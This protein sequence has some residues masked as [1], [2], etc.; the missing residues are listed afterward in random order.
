[1]TPKPKYWLLALR[2]KTLTLSVIP[3]ITGSAL[4]W[5]QAGN[6]SVPVMLTAVLVAVLIQIGTNLHND[7]SDSA[8]GTDN[9]ATRLGPPRAVAQGWL[10]ARSV[11]RAALA[12]FLLALV[13]GLYLV[14]VGGWPILLLGLLSIAS[15]YLYTGGPRPIARSGMGEAFVLFFFGVVA[16]SGSAYLQSGRFTLVAALCGLLLGLPAAAVLL[17]NNHRDRD[18]DA[19]AGRQTLAVHYGGKLSQRLYAI[20]V[21]APFALL[22]LVQLLTMD[23]RIAYMPCLV[24][25]W[26][27]RLIS[28]FRHITNPR[29][30]NPLLAETALFQLALGL[31]LSLTFVASRMSPIAD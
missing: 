1:M 5:W 30:F 24:M 13:S 28:R 2:P 9:P 26:A 19:L 16:V 15:G 23:L 3:V 20:G 29:D 12:S 18:G 31:L 22:P 21:L 8:S 10:S 25:P 17:I 4:G 7:A 27:L 6:L 11:Q 14:S